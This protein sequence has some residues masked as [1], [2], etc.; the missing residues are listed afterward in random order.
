MPT[1][2][3]ILSKI[4]YVL[5]LLSNKKIRTFLADR[6]M[7][8]LILAVKSGNFWMYNLGKHPDKLAIV[9][10]QR[11][12]TYRELSERISRFNGGLL[13]LGLS[14]GDRVAVVVHNCAE[15]L[16]T[17]L[18]PGFIGVKTVPVNWHLKTDEIEYVLNNSG[19]RVV[20]VSERFADSIIGLRSRLENVQEVIV[21]GDHVA[22]DMTSYEEFIRG[23]SPCPK[24]G[25]PGGGLMFYTSGTTGK[26][27]GASTRALQDISV[28]TPDDLADLLL[29]MSNM[30]LGFDWDKTTNIHL[31]TAPLYHTSPIAL[32]GLT[33]YASGTVV[34][35]DKFDAVE[36]LQ[37]IEN[38]KISTTYMP[39][40]L[41]RRIMSCA[42]RD[43]YDVSSMKSLVSAAAPCPADLKKEIIGVFGPVFY[44][45]YGSTDAAVNTILKPEHYRN[46]PDKLRSVGRVAQGNKM[47]IVNEDNVEL[48]P[49]T[50]GD[51]LISNAMVKY[52]EYHNEPEK[53]RNAFVE[54]GGENYFREGEVACLDE[55]QFCYIAD[56]KKDMIISGGVNIYPAEIEEVLLLHCSVMDAAVIGLPDEEWGES[57]KAVVVLKE[58]K[59]CS[60]EEIITYCKEKLAGFKIPKSVDFVDEL[61]RSPTGKLMKRALKEQCV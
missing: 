50:V 53:T 43:Q 36:A 7:R 32:C 3:S 52:L 9:D 34:I 39:P 1:N 21:V 38:E 12:I 23:S 13:S 14:P 45:F 40:I 4:V 58:G 35:M 42:E 5:K 15:F 37:L 18:G 24:K 48:P 27:K 49:N 41:L 56:R 44:E 8:N 19:A 46:D 20:V 61:P 11:R 60:E 10:G 22:H 59:P 28:L 33:F 31:A 51:L 30:L 55:D 6:E 16:E 54:I 57:I 25:I 17:M 26:P 2:G 29:L 47:I